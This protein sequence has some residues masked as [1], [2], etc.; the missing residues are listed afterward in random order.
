MNGRGTNVMQSLPFGLGYE[1]II[2]NKISERPQ[3]KFPV[4]HPIT[5]K[6]RAL[7]V[8]C[9]KYEESVKDGPFYTG[10]LELSF[11]TSND[12][13]GLHTELLVEEGGI[14][15]GLQ[16]YS[17]RYLKKRKIGISIDEHPFRLELFPQ[18]LYSVMGINKRKLLKIA[19]KD[20]V[21]DD[22]FTGSGLNEVLDEQ[23]ISLLEKLKDL[24]ED[25][26]NDQDAD[27]EED[28]AREEDLDDEFEEDD[29]DDYNAERY[30]DDD[31]EDDIE[32]GDDA[33]EADF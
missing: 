19:S 13:K 20:Q 11:K 30:F 32:D 9:I 10:S 16:R 27:K 2:R 26:D 23:G 24:A 7:A 4:N 21:K 8:A 3:I 5:S 6:E 17:D 31:N 14:N 33:H 22:L 18:E 1:D 12:H 25:V 28:E 15:D 29:S